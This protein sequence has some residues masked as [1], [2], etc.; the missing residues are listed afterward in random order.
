MKTHDAR[1]KRKAITETPEKT[2]V[3]IRKKIQSLIFSVQLYWL[4]LSTVVTGTVSFAS[5]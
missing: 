5:L 3:S 1:K 4:Y 2:K